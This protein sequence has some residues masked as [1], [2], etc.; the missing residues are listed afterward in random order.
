MPT[1]RLIWF[2]FI[3]ACFVLLS[4]S[5]TAVRLY[6]DYLWFGEVGFRSIFTTIL[7]TQFLLG[8]I[9]GL[10]T[11]GILYLN[12][13]TA[14]HLASRG[15]PLVFGE[16]SEILDRSVQSIKVKRFIQGVSLFFGLILGLD[17]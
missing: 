8:G 4:L 13:R 3:A 15:I 6:T 10:L 12:F 14:D 5:S 9:V 17:A 1:R 11:T 2:L 16:L 7:T